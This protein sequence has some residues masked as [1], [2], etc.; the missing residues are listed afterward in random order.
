MFRFIRR[1][2]VVL[3]ILFVVYLMFKAIAPNTTKTLT[4]KIGSFYITSECDDTECAPVVS[5]WEVLEDENTIDSMEEKK[6]KVWFRA[7]IRNFF[8]S[9]DSEDVDEEDENG[10]DDMENN[11]E[12][13]IFTWEV[14]TGQVVVVST[15]EVAVQTTGGNTTWE[16]EEIMPTISDEQKEA[17]K[18]IDSLF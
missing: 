4:D 16:K 12:V 3:I 11:D 5:T 1:L 13:E 7:R 8:S 6:E 2:I 10:K 9:D 17:Q 18:V 14:E 15:W